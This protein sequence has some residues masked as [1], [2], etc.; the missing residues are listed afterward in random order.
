M[1]DRLY[2]VRCAA[3][4]ARNAVLQRLRFVDHAASDSTCQRSAPATD[5]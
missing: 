1:L 4:H 3:D 2:A 5:R